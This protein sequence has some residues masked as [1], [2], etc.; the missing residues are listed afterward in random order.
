VAVALE[1]RA[2]HEDLA[3]E[4]EPMSTPQI[5]GDD[6]VDFTGIAWGSVEWTLLC[7]LYLRAHE[8]RQPDSILRDQY[9]QDAVDRIDYDFAR[10]H[11]TVRPSINQYGAALR[12]AYFDAAISDFLAMHPEGT[13]IHLGCGLHSRAF[14]IA[15]PSARW[16]DVDLPQIIALRRQLYSETSTYRMIGSSVTE[17]DW[18][19]QLPTGGPAMIAAEG[20]L[21]YVTEHEVADLLGRLT[22]RFDTGELVAD[23]LSPWGP[24]LSRILTSGIITW[25]T[26][27]GAEITRATP[28][29]RLIDE[30]SVVAGFDRIPRKGPRLLYRIQHRVPVT[31]DYD[32]LYRYTF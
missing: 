25:G 30:R 10:I 6:R 3:R 31:R 20:L 17:S 29:L 13:V 14:R 32:K 27:D 19:D 9:A 18:I 28:V 16:F 23:L 24:R 5:S 21:M 1:A 11:R 8:S 12:G 26:R 7:M 4:D 2:T 22:A 15:T